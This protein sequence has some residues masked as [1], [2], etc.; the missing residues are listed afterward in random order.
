MESQPKIT[1][2]LIYAVVVLIGLY[3]ISE[4]SISQKN[5]SMN[6]RAT[7]NDD[8]TTRLDFEIYNSYTQKNPIQYSPWEYLAEPH[9]EAT[10]SIREAFSEGD[11]EPDRY[12]WE[13]DG[14]EKK[15][16]STISH[17]FTSLGTTPIKITDTETDIS[18]S[19][20]VMVKY[21]RREIRTLTD[22]DRNDVL[23]ALET[24]YRLPTEE[25]MV[26]FGDD[27]RGM[28]YFLK[29][30][31][32]GAG[33]KD[34]DHWHDDAG[35]MTHHI[36]YTMEVEQSMQLVNPRVAMPYWDYTID[37]YLYDS[38]LGDSVVWSDDWFGEMSPDNSL[39]IITKGRWKFLK[40]PESGDFTIVNPYG[41]LRTPWNVNPTKHI[42]RSNYVNGQEFTM[43]VG[44]SELYTA[45]KLTS[46]A[47]INEQ[48]NGETHG[49]V[50]VRIGGEWD[51]LY[52]KTKY[53]INEGFSLNEVLLAKILWRAGYLRVPDSCEEG[54]DCKA[55]CPRE[56][57]EHQGKTAYDVIKDFGLF[58]YMVADENMEYDEELDQFHL[59][60][61]WN[62]EAEKEF[63]EDL[64][65]TICDPGKV[66]EMYTSAAPADP[67]FW[68]LHPAAERFL[69]LRRIIGDSYPDIYPF[70]ETWGY[71][72][73]DHI[74]SDNGWVCD[75]SDVEGW[76]DVPNCE[77]S[78]ACSGHAV[79]DVLEFAF[80]G[81]LAGRTFTNQEY[82]DFMH[83]FTE[84]LPYLYDNYDFDHCLEQGYDFF[85]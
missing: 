34:C 60:D 58:S 84:D 15:A 9:R 66:G 75:W 79:D 42:T 22:E 39:H 28:D 32:I 76:L 25:G 62:T 70:D 8:S 43:G 5:P 33:Q 29:E 44:C 35:I 71:Q 72:H 63:F 49:P 83:P 27:Y 64:L 45:F 67:S 73:K 51:S 53:D 2:A 85:D 18:F 12:V 57:Y 26:I 19:T 74:A 80:T 23:D 30:H 48:L 77:D 7:N 6:F 3:G 78:F 38:N 54:E 36:A 40:F 59:K 4:I 52:S 16:G 82:Y 21:V 37:D 10:L 41:L 11:S 13:I 14:E 65:Q 81:N 56:I 24:I 50:H 61:Q 55:S 31:L 20:Q 69:N 46:L 1:T 47:E 68:I 17:T